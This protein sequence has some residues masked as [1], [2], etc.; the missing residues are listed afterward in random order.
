[1]NAGDWLNL[2]SRQSAEIIVGTWHSPRCRQLV[3]RTLFRR[4]QTIR[5]PKFH[6]FKSKF[7][8]IIDGPE[9]RHFRFG[10]SIPFETAVTDLLFY[11]HHPL[12]SHLNMGIL[13]IVPVGFFDII[14][15]DASKLMDISL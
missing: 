8:V 7:D 4:R 2:R 14:V 6:D 3:L 13:D 9:L 15:D 5:N 1:M 10:E 11:H 12:I